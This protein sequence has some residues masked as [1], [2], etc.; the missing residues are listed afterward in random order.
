MKDNLNAKKI[1]EN[2]I[3]SARKEVENVIKRR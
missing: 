3:F 1:L 2:H